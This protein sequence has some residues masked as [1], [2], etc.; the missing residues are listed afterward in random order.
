[1]NSEKGRD[2]HALHVILGDVVSYIKPQNILR[3][4]I[5]HFGTC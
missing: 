2:K 1:M 3:T 5:F 4:K